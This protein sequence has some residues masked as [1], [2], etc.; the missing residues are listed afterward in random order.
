[1]AA[2]LKNNLQVEDVDK[3]TSAELLTAIL[4]PG[5][6]ARFQEWRE[7]KEA[8]GMKDEIMITD[9]EHHP[10]SKGHSAGKD[11]PVLMRNSCILMLGAGDADRN[12]KIATPLEYAFAMGFHVYEHS[13]RSFPLTEWMEISKSNASTR[14]KHAMGNGMSLI[15]QASWMVYV[16][17][18]VVLVETPNPLNDQPLRRSSSW[19]EFPDDES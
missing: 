17:S 16:L 6:V 15:T 14:L 19:D 8:A 2:K 13:P 4:P 11:W 7:F 12:W 5:G 1:M 9:L 18:N 3:L 10:G